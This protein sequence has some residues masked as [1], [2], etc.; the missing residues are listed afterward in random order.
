MSCVLMTI[1]DN[2][3]FIT[4]VQIPYGSGEDAIWLGG[5]EEEQY[6]CLFYE[7]ESSNWYD[8][9]WILM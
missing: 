4:N 6:P 2:L 3:Y 9:F 1:G 7:S 5:K 8:K